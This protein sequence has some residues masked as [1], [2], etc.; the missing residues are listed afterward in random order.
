MN[1]WERIA[2]QNKLRAQLIALIARDANVSERY[3]ELKAKQIAHDSKTLTY[4]D[5]LDA[6]RRGVIKL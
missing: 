5:V 1:A 4:D 3:V 6:M 2:A